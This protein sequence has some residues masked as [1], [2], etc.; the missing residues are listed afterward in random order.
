MYLTPGMSFNLVVI[1][2]TIYRPS[3][4]PEELLQILEL[5]SENLA[6]VLTEEERMEEGFV[7]LRYSMDQLQKMQGCCPQIIALENQHVI[8][9]A[10]CLHPDLHKDVPDLEPLFKVLDAFPEVMGDFRIM[11]QICIRK[12]HRGK[13]HLL[14]L[15]N[16]MRKHLGRVPI[17]TEISWS[18]PRSL[19]AHYALGFQKLTDHPGGGQQWDVVCWE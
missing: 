10:L 2:N 9:Y 6:E 17:I 4:S 1:L 18:N 8:G 13:G 12:G 3:E 11:G 16:C 5:Q 19:R 14:G 15:Y 7:T